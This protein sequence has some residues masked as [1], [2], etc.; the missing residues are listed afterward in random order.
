M[1]DKKSPF[2]SYAIIEPIRF[3]FA[4]ESEYWWEIKPPTA[5]DELAL[6]RYMNTGKAIYNA[7]GGM[8]TEGSPSWLDILFY[9]IALLFG[10]TNIPADADKP[11]SDDG[12]PFISEKST[13]ASI[14]AK[15]RKMPMEMVAEI[16]DKIAECVPGWGPKNPL[17][18]ANQSEE[19]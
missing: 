4:D 3:N 16:A 10:G 7:D 6:T 19:D 13:M 1:A 12:K 15:L 18:R 8:E 14:E 11:V 5:G 2:G 17:S 9:E